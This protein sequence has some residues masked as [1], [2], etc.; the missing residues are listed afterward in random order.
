[1]HWKV[2]NCIIPC[3]KE[4]NT[5]YELQNTIMSKLQNSIKHGTFIDNIWSSNEFHGTLKVPWNLVSS[6]N[7][8]ELFQAWKHHHYRRHR[9]R[10]HRHHHHHHHHVI[11]ITMI[12][13][14][15]NYYPH[16]HH[17]RRHYHNVITI[18]S[19]SSSS[20]WTTAAPWSSPQPQSPPT[21]PS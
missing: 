13:T 17:H 19:S 10:H 16:H 3:N 2:Y 18:I 9:H 5:I 4:Q 6:P 1:M 14:I 15:T 21:L 7:F 20:Y 11:I 8:M 12:I